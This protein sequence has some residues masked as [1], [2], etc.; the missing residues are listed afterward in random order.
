MARTTNSLVE[1]VALLE[2]SALSACRIQPSHL[3][4]L[5]NWF[6]D[7]LGVRISSD[8][9]MEGINE[10]VHRIFT[11]PVRIQDLQNPTVV[12]SSLLGGKNGPRSA[13]HIHW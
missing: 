3:P 13:S 10:F 4:M 5:V 2:A 7:P 12:S 1:L 6:G 8:S 9:F 11:N